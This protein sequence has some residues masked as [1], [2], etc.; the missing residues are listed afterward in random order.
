MDEKLF[1]S[2]YFSTMPRWYSVHLRERQAE[3]LVAIDK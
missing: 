2:I 1:R 3:F